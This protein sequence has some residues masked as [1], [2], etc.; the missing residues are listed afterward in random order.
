[1]LCHT[2]NATH[3]HNNNTRSLVGKIYRRC[4]IFVVDLFQIGLVLPI[5]YNIP[6]KC[7]QDWCKEGGG[8]NENALDAVVLMANNGFLF[9]LIA[10]Y[11][12]S[13]AFYNF[14]GLSVS[15]KLSSIHRTLV[16]PWNFYLFFCLF[17]W[18]IIAKPVRSIAFVLC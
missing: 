12:I 4:I 17:S 8:V 5:V 16:S 1:M 13:I 11:V 14:F 9:A 10:L 3:S 15:K 2:R 6:P 7:D 18:Y